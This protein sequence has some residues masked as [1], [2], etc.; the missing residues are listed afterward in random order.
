MLDLSNAK[1]AHAAERLRNES[2]VWFTTVSP[3]GI[4]EPTPVWFLWDGGDEMLIYT[5][6][7][8]LKVRNIRENDRVAVNLNSD[9]HGGDVV[10]FLGRAALD[11]AAPAVKDNPAYVE[12]YRRGMQNIGLTPESMSESYSQP[13]RVTMTH[14][15]VEGSE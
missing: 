11:D 6:P 12:K 1:H 4:P 2:V 15:R 10:V 5:P 8:S 13:I 14:T 9:E 3:D 7:D